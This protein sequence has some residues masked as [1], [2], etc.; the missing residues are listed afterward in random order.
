MIISRTGIRSPGQKMLV[1]CEPS[2][3]R[4]VVIHSVTEKYTGIWCRGSIR[5]SLR[6][7]VMHINPRWSLAQMPRRE[8]QFMRLI[9]L[10][11]LK[12]AFWF[13]RAWGWFL[14]KV[15][16][17]NQSNIQRLIVRVN[18]WRCSMFRPGEYRHILGLIYSR[19]VQVQD[20]RAGVNILPFIFWE[21]NGW[22]GRMIL[23]PN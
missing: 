21:E 20:T 17:L 8:C 3:E 22:K 7:G 10:M 9:S 19:W 11:G 6:R 15:N 23:P 14:C 13:L 12:C 16:K 18:C 4:G 2:N 5:R 1:D